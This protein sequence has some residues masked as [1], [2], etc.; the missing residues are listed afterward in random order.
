MGHPKKQRRKHETPKKPWDKARIEHEQ[1]LLKN[2]GLRRKKE[3]WR[4]E[5]VLRDFRRR[6]RELQAHR[7]E[8]A[9]K[10]LL[11]RLNAMGIPCE[12]L[13]DLLEVRVED[14]L[15]RRLQS[16]IRRKGIAR[17]PLHARQFIVHGKVR[18]AGRKILWPSYIVLKKDESAIALDEVMT[19]KN[20]AA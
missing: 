9:E 10:T 7:S 11:E 13:D 14:I 4:A 15:S 6:A 5:S 12:M 2:Y 19:K 17:T 3:L 8:A 1:H 20:E 18:I 16:F